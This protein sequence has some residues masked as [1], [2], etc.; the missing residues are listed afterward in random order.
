MNIKAFLFAPLLFIISCAE[1][2]NRSNQFEITEA[3]GFPR[4][5]KDKHY[6]TNQTS[7]IAFIGRDKNNLKTFLTADDIGN[8][9]HLKIKDDTLLYLSPINFSKEAEIFLDT[10]PKAD[11]EDITYDK[12]SRRAFVS[13]EGNLPDPKKYTC[14][15]QINFE[16]EDPFSDKIVSFK[17]LNFKPGNLFFKYVDNNMG[18]EGLAVDSNYFYLGLEGIKKNNLFA[19]STLILI[20]G[21]KDLEIKK[22]INTKNLGI[23]S[24]CGLYSPNNRNIIGVD[25][26]KRK[27]VRIIFNDDLTVKRTFI[28]EVDIK[29]PS[30]PAFS[31]VASL[32]SVSMDDQNCIYLVDDPWKQF[33]IP[34][35]QILQKIDSTAVENF[36]NFV[37]I[38]YKFKLE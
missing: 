9:H 26:N 37:P 32:E 36:K 14:I 8:I 33:F 11:F 19:D 34:S 28:K 30:F 5:L 12:F 38:I 17:K 21:K 7:G 31:Y 35:N 29:I 3:K 25:R 27:I 18:Y 16:N 6:S 4:W 2:T 13:I 15:C 1:Y 20:A 24:V 10:F 23:Q 22:L